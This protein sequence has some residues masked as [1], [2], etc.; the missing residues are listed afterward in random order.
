M[1]CTSPVRRL[2]KTRQHKRTGIVKRYY[3][4]YS[5]ISV[6]PQRNTF[7]FIVTFYNGTQCLTSCAE[8][9]S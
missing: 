5:V 2:A 3:G 8:E 4:L 7:C 9:V 6:E 1:D